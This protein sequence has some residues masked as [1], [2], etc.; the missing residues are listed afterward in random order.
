MEGKRIKKNFFTQEDFIK[1]YQSWE[2]IVEEYKKLDDERKLYFHMWLFG[3]DIYRAFYG[4]VFLF[5]SVLKV[6]EALNEGGDEVVLGSGLNVPDWLV[7][8]YEGTEIGQ[9]FYVPFYFLEKDG[10][11]VFNGKRVVVRAMI[12]LEREVGELIEKVWELNDWEV[13]NYLIEFADKLEDMLKE[14]RESERKTE[15]R[16][17]VRE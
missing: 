8:L 10:L 17:L 5:D 2:K 4:Y 12:E 11:I 7:D 13:L 15:S 1:F 6:A 16:E 14:I 3:T 9:F